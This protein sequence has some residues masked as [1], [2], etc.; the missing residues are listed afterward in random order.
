MR[1]DPTPLAHSLERWMGW[2]DLHHNGIRPVLAVH[3]LS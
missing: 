1:L 2:E 3:F